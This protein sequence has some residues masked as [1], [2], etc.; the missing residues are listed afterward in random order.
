VARAIVDQRKELV[1]DPKSAEPVAEI[2]GDLNKRPVLYGDDSVV[3][4]ALRLVQDELR[5]D[6]APQQLA[7][8]EQL[9]WQTAVRIEDGRVGM[10][11]NDLRQIEKKLQDALAR[12]APDA[13]IDRLMRQMQQALDRYMQAMAQELQRHPGEQMQT[14]LDPSRMLT[15]RDLQRMLDHARELARSGDREQARQLLSQLQNMLENLRA[16]RPGEMS[17]SARQA[18]QMMHGL[19]QLMQRQKN[20]LD[21]S[22]RARNQAG[23]EGQMRPDGQ[24]GEQSG[25]PQ[26]GAQGD[27]GESQSPGEDAGQQEDLRHGLGEL[28]RKLGDGMGEIPDPFGR[29]ERAMHDAVGALRQGQPGDA[30]APQTEALDQLQQGAREFAR[31][32]QQRMGVGDAE[33]SQMGTVRRGERGEHGRDPFGRPMS[34]GG[35]FDEGDVKIPDDNILQKSREILDELRRRAGERSRPQIELDYIDRLLKRF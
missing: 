32:M 31:Q 8:L 5:A 7:A 12:N 34:N 4:L 1:K 16:G 9:M 11:E 26:Q 28:M 27:A 30:I 21:R 25:E 18:Q 13:E 15:S 24:P 3:F 22:F 14:P 33:S 29:A 19:Q 23:Q 10:A 35:L 20:L 2:L 17:K 6:P